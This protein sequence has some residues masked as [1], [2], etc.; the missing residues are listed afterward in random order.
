MKFRAWAKMLEVEYGKIAKENSLKGLPC[1]TNDPVGRVR[2]KIALQLGTN[3]TN[4]KRAIRIENDLTSPPIGEYVRNDLT[5]GKILPEGRKIFLTFRNDL[6][7]CD[8]FNTNKKV[9]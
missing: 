9:R 5:S 8:K 6:P 4:L 7:S 1:G 3:K 2:D